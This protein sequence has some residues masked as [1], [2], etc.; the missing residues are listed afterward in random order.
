VSVFLYSYYNNVSGE[1]N[2]VVKRIL[3]FGAE[4][5]VALLLIPLDISICATPDLITMI[6][7]DISQSDRRINRNDLSSLFT[8]HSHCILISVIISSVDGFD[9]GVRPPDSHARFEHGSLRSPRVQ[10][11][12]L[13]LFIIVIYDHE[14]KGIFQ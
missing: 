5:R 10:V 2:R 4:G 8:K 3:D 13:H 9:V 11:S 14:G 6:P 12:S 1:N 7:L